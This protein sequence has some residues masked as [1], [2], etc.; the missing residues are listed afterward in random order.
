LLAEAQPTARGWTDLLTAAG[1]RY[2]L[3]P[4]QTPEL[5]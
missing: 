2:R 4:D 5:L 3:R 1:I